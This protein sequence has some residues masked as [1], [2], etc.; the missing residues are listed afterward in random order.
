[1]SAALLATGALLAF[2][3]VRKPVQAVPGTAVE[4]TPEPALATL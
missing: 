4:L 1:V 3:F 2:L